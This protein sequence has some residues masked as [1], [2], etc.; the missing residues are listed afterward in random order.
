MSWSSSNLGPGS[1]ALR[2]EDYAL[3]GDCHT[4]SAGRHRRLDRLA[5]PA[6]IRFGGLLRRAAGH[7][8]KWPLADRAAVDDHRHAT[9][10]PRRTP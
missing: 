2:I 3:I 8:T 10:L 6:A 4:A 5:V 7:G 1:M 9:T